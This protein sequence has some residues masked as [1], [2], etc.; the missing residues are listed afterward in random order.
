MSIAPSTLVVSKEVN[1]QPDFAGLKNLE[2]RMNQSLIDQPEA[3]HCVAEMI[4][5]VRTGFY[6]EAKPRGVLVFAGPTGVGKTELAKMTAYEMG[7]PLHRFDMSEFSESHKVSRLLGSP[8]GYVN[9]DR[10]GELVNKLKSTPA[11]VVLF[12]EIE[13]AH[14]DIYKIF[15]Q[16]FDEGRLTDSM[17]EEVNATETIFILTTNLASR[18]I[19]QQMER[20]VRDNLD[21]RLKALCIRTF[22]AELYN[23]FDKVVVFRPL[24][25]PAMERIVEKYLRH[26]KDGLGRRK[27][28][29]TWDQKV[30]VHLAALNVDLNMGAR[31]IHRKIKEHLLPKLTASRIEGKILETDAKVCMKVVDGQ[32]ELLV[33]DKGKVAVAP[34]PEQSTSVAEGT[35]GKKEAIILKEG[36]VYLDLINERPLQQLEGKHVYRLSANGGDRSYMD[37]CIKI[38]DVSSTGEILYEDNIRILNKEG[39]LRLLPSRWNDGEWRPVTPARNGRAFFENVCTAIDHP[40]SQKQA[41]ILVKKIFTKLEDDCH[42]SEKAPFAHL[43][44]YCIK[45]K[46]EDL[47]ID[48]EALEKLIGPLSVKILSK[49]PTR[50]SNGISRPKL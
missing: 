5:R 7:I 21:E 46:K 44:E 28:D 48:L 20:A 33:L 14:P 3:V 29:M 41:L 25:Q 35:P 50:D 37:N 18:E 32:L 11:C 31:D 27:L 43:R 16:L 26:L 36:V 15:L 9:S 12:D 49:E 17:G 23:R 24:S 13:K 4:K 45:E 1:Q 10:G 42:L 47:L 38:V 6:D 34:E 19:Y 39:H 30:V 8:S 22:S 40:S 2:E